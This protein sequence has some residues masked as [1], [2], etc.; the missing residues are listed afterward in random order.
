MYIIDTDALL[1][2]PGLVQADQLNY[3][4]EELVELVEDGKLCFPDYVIA[5]CRRIA[6]G[7]DIALWVRSIS[8]SRVHK[9]VAYA[10]TMQVMSAVPEL[11][12]EDTED[13]SSQVAVA[14]MACYASQALDAQDVCVVTE[15]RSALPTRICLADACAELQIQEISVMEFLKRESLSSYLLDGDA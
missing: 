10:F 1:S 6:N 5:E 14:A 7:E 4:L 12:D 15:D 9:S 2:I 8:G 3:L 11:L 13:E